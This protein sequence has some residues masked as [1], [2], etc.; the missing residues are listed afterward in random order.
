MRETLRLEPVHGMLRIAVR[1]RTLNL[2]ES[3]LNQEGHADRVEYH[4]H[5]LRKHEKHGRTITC[6]FVPAPNLEEQHL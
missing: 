2:K 4:A 6:S 3:R 1:R 5:L